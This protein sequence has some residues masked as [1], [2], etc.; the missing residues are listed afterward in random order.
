VTDRHGPPARHAARPNAPTPPKAV[1]LD[2]LGTLLDLAPPAPRLQRELALRGIEVAEAV[3]EHAFRV[4]V[5][6]YLTHHLE[7]RDDASVE[8]LRD[9]CA[10]VTAEALGQGRERVAAVRSALLAAISFVALPDAAPALGALRAAGLR[11]VVAS[12]WDCSLSRVLTDAGLGSLLDGVVTSADV[13]APK[14]A[15]PVF[16]AALDLAGCRPEEAVLIGDS[17]EHDVAG[18]RAVGIEAILLARASEPAVEHPDVTVA[19]SLDAAG[20]LILARVIGGSAPT[21]AEDG[22]P[23]SARR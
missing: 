4:E 6:H 22:P 23:G 9:A 7:G 11:L 3:A 19:R 2:C 5:A 18:A 21:P 13:G 8:R 17:L 16:D 14:P 1:L 20:S 15:R 10:A 12:N